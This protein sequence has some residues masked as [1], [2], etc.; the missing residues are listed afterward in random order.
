MTMTHILVFCALALLTCWVIPQR[1]RIWALLGSSTLAVYWLQPATPIRNLDFWLPTASILLTITTWA[2]VR[3][4]GHG[5]RRNTLLGV[6]FIAGVILIIALGR[7]LEP[8]CCLIPTRP[9]A[10]LQ[11]L[12]VLGFFGALI[13]LFASLNRFKRQLAWLTIFLILGLFFV[14]KSEPFAQLVNAGLRRMSGQDP[15]LAGADDL[16]WLG[17]SF[18]AFR[19]LHVLLDFRKRGSPDYSLG[20]FVTY[21]LFYPAY[22]AGPIDRAERFIGD[23]RQPVSTRAENTTEGSRRILIGLFKKF[24]IADSLVLISLNAQNAG[25][26]SSPFWMW[27]LLYAYTLR[28]YFDFAGYTDIALGIGRYLGIKLP[29]NFNSP[30]LK[31]SLTS[32]WNSWHITLAMWFRAYFFNPL[33]RALRSN[34]RLPTWLVILVGQLGTMLL[35]GLWHG[36]TW[37]FAIWGL[38]HGAGLFINNRWSEFTRSRLVHIDGRPAYHSLLSFTGWV[39]T[40]QFVALG[41]VWF[42]LPSINLSL[43]VFQ[44]LFGL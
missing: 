40:F 24:V 10:F 12:L 38:W 36:I 25:Q 44:T 26:T 29:E 23:L 34:R 8:L 20:N 18:L 11:L 32:F 22:T 6:G 16:L 13:A 28:I 39:L 17:F 5:Q 42:A 21:A 33:T 7:Y 9:P 43:E 31:S 1:W 2:I 15:S 4:A 30:Y 27:L 3:Q 41:W 37:N 35:I 19:L 14:L